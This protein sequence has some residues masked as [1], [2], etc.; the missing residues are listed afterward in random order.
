MGKNVK[1]SEKKALEVTEVP[2]QDN[3]KLLNPA[4]GKRQPLKGFDERFVDIVDYHLRGT[5]RIWEERG[6]GRIYDQYGHN[7]PVWTPNGLTYGRDQVIADTLQVQHTFPDRKLYTD[8][9]IWKAD[10]A[11][12]VYQFSAGFT[13]VGHHWGY[14]AYGPPTGKKLTWGVL[15]DCIVHENRIAEEW[16]IRDDTAIL[17]QLGL[18]LWEVARDLAEQDTA[19]P[20]EKSFYS[21]LDRTD[22]QR[23]PQ[24]YSPKSGSFDV[25]DF[26]RSVLHDQWNVRLLN[27][28][29]KHYAPNYQF[30]GPGNRRL[31]GTGDY[32]A[33]ATMLLAQF[34]DL[35]YQIDEL[36]WNEER[37]KDRLK[38]A[39]RW[40]IQGTHEGWGPFGKPTGRRMQLMGMS[41]HYVKHEKLV[42]EFTLYSEIALLKQL[43]EI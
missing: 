12:E 39:V 30:R 31:Y 10:H 32:A 25:E 4:P 24:R 13:N 29:A 7:T 3:S 26:L 15:C 5:H 41:Q 11:K 27:R 35:H 2:W 40:T 33:H 8:D 16:L 18:D 14:S 9:V 36:Y 42:E 19:D 28:I 17:R 23:I 20:S 43:V 6:V 1:L 38:L 22:G 37:L 34:P 21:H